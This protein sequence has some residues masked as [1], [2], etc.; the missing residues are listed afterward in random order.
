MSDTEP[1]DVLPPW[2]LDKMREAWADHPSSGSAIEALHE[3]FAREVLAPMHPGADPDDCVLPARSYSP[4]LCALVLAL[5]D[6]ARE[7]YAAFRGLV[8]AVALG[9]VLEERG[10][11]LGEATLDAALHRVVGDAGRHLL[12]LGRVRNGI[13]FRCGNPEADPHNAVE[14]E[15]RRYGVR[16]AAE[17]LRSTQNELDALRT[18]VAGLRA[19]FAGLTDN[20][21]DPARVHDWTWIDANRPAPAETESGDFSKRIIGLEERALAAE[22]SASQAAERADAAEA[23]LHE[24]RALLLDCPFGHDTERV[25]FLRSEPESARVAWVDRVHTTA[26]ALPAPLAPQPPQ[27][28]AIDPDPG[29]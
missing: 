5:F 7:Q 18:W 4:R 13:I 12:R 22:R 8:D 10:P 11:E 25:L 3:R 29:A 28:R 27:D 26:K 19:D 16:G 6:D 21:A 23:R 2:L 1:K 24:L 17:A 15:V 14:V 9:Q 20:A